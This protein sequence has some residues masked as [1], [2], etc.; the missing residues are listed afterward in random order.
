[1]HNAMKA[2]VMA[3]ASVAAGASWA[4]MESVA[5]PNGRLVVEAG[6]EGGKLMWSAERKGA[7]LVMPSALGL[8]FIERGVKGPFRLLDVKRRTIDSAWTTRFYRKEKVVDRANEMTLFFEGEG[9]GRIDVVVR[10]YDDGFAF[11]YVVPEQKGFD[12]FQLKGELTEW[13]LAP[14]AEGWI[15]SYKTFLTSQECA[16]E[17]RKVREISPNEILG[18]PAVVEAGG[19]CMALCEAGLTDWAGL[20]YRVPAKGQPPD[21]AVL[22]AAL[23]PL[24]ASSAS[25]SGVAVIRTTPA[26][27]PWRV[28][29]CGDTPLDLAAAGADIVMNLNPP[30]EEGMDFS[31]VAPGASSWAMILTSLTVPLTGKW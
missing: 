10:A 8:D 28:A 11:R 14:E 15:T 9:G 7:K 25:A 6:E 17:R 22:T 1:M 18:M 4:R 23:A 12:G 13:R 29:I 30:P 2:L 24:P 27:S 5:S 20:F 21:A 31:W 26:A 16:F 19:Q 3:A